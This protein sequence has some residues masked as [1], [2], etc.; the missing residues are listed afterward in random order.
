[1]ARNRDLKGIQ[2]GHSRVRQTRLECRQSCRT[3]ARIYCPSQV[4]RLKRAGYRHPETRLAGNPSAHPLFKG[5]EAQKIREISK[6]R[7]LIPARGGPGR[8][9]VPMDGRAKGQDRGHP[10]RRKT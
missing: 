6:W 4:H 7:F 2:D 5:Y 9:A 10:L 1:M 8:T 3:G